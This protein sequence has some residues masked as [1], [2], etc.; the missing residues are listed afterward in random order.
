MSEDFAILDISHLPVLSGTAEPITGQRK[1][2]GLCQF[3]FANTL[4]L[5]SPMEC[6]RHAP[7]PFPLIIPNKGVTINAFHPPVSRDHFCYEFEFRKK[8]D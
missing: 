2:C 8:E 1:R 3:S 4:D 7:M 6:R 5:K